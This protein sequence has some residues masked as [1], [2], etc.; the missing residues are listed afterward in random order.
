VGTSK[1]TIIHGAIEGFDGTSDAFLYSNGV[2]KDLGRLPRGNYSSG[3]AINNLMQIVGVSNTDSTKSPKGDYY[4]GGTVDGFIYQQGVMRSLGAFYPAK[5]NNGDKMVGYYGG[6]N[7]IAIYANG[8]VERTGITGQ[9][10]GLND[11]GQFCG[12]TMPENLPWKAFIY[13]NAIHYIGT[14]PGYASSQ[15]EGVNNSG[16]V[17]GFC[18]NDAEGQAFIWNGVTMKAIT[19][20]GWNVTDAP[21]INDAGQICITADRN[22]GTPQHEEHAM[23]LTP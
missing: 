13:T 17:V 20:P 1:G 5:I 6:T 14:L 18:Y 4:V 21:G 12:W 7:A 2:M 19:V 11:H 3:Y 8:R 10:S 15:A 22:L 23:I 16:E 9:V